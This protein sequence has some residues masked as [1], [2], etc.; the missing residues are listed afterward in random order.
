MIQK[1]FLNR[2]LFSSPEEKPKPDPVLKT[3]SPVLRLALSGEKKEQAGPT[4][5]ITAIESIPELPLP[6]SPTAI[7]PLARSTI[8]SPTSVALSSQPI[9]TTAIDDRCELSSSKEDTVPIPSPT[10][11]T[12][13]SDPLPTDEIDDDIC[14]KSCSVAPNDIPLISSTNLINEMNGVNEKLPATESIVEIVK[15]EVLP[16]TLELEI[17]ENPPEEMKV[18]CVPTPITPSIVPSFSPSPPTPPAS[19]PPTPVIVPAA[20]TSVN[21]GSGPTGVQRVFEEDENIR[22]CLSEDAKEIQNKVEV[23]ADGQTEEIVDSQ[24]LSSR[25]SP[26][27]G[28][29]F[30]Y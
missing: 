14:K 30:C 22:T 12:E 8:T 20:A 26:V 11:C 15:Q 16:L 19:P 17:L 13:A 25:K 2:F 1:L 5:E 23:E 29:S 10:S 6:P 3:P 4:S 28:K 18:E 27:P 9:F 24:N 7:S 21:T